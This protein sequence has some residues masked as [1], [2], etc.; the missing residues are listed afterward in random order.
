MFSK[1]NDP[2]SAPTRPAATNA[3]KSVLAS[4]LKIS[5]DI[6]SSGSV[7]VLGEVDG[8]I[9]ARS[10]TI[11]A[12]GSVKGDITA[13]VAEVKGAID[14]RVKTQDFTLRS[15]ARA[16]TDVVYTTLTIDSGAQIEGRFSRNKG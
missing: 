1:P 10:L 15:T 12:E 7:E 9:S 11:G 3:G 5:G 14:G 6:T 2:L 13:E 16:K 8:T 4:D